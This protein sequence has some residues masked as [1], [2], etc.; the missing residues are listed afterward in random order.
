[1]L[2]VLQK[3]STQYSNI[4]QTTDQLQYRY[5]DPES[6]A[7]HLLPWKQQMIQVAQYYLKEQILSCKALFFNIATT[8]SYAFLPVINK[9]LRV[10]LI[11]SAPDKTI[12]C[13]TLFYT[14]ALYALPCQMP[15]RQIAPLLPSVT[16]QKNITGYLVGRSYLYC[17]SNTI[18]Y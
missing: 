5:A 18:L 17:H 1:M 15:F 3:R 14:F 8:I 13:L 7:F 12:H 16:Q 9:S 2:D 11:K 6:N 4:Q 10:A